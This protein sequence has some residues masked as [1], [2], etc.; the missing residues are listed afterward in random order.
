MMTA[1][2]ENRLI[3]QLKRGIPLSGVSAHM[4]YNKNA[5]YKI[6]FCTIIP[7]AKV[8]ILLLRTTPEE[9]NAKDITFKVHQIYVVSQGKMREIKESH[10][11]EKPLIFQHSNTFYNMNLGGSLF[12]KLYLL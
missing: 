5:Y 11:L 12:G 8:S 10:L 2:H 6:D 9:E 7:K 4:Y 1:E 3:E